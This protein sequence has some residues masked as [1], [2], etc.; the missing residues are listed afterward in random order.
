V[1]QT[2]I[3]ASA[4][5]ARGRRRAGGAIALA[6][7]ALLLALALAPA[8]AAATFRVSP[9]VLE[10]RRRGGEAALGTIDVALKGERAA[11][12]RVVVQDIRQLPDGS[13]AYAPPSGSP[14]SASAWIAVAPRR[15]AGGPDRVQ[16]VQYRVLVPANAEPGDHLASIAVQRLP[17]RGAATAVPVEAISARLTVRVPGRVAPAAKIVGL[18]APGV[19]DGGPVAIEASVRNTGNVTLDFDRA[20]RGRVAVLD[21]GKAKASQPFEGLLFPGQTRSYDLAWDDPPLF[22]DFEAVASVDAGARPVHESEGFWVIPWRQIAAL[23]LAALAAVTLALGL[24]R[25]RWGY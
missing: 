2:A 14:F 18:D 10:A 13:R 7:A 21:G 22:G 9:T 5:G 1:G 23:A 17:P 11:R 15:F 25:R 19:A 20:T 4:S 8:N 24:R 6:C 3:T 16:P 12:F